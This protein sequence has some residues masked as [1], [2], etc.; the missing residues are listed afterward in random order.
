MGERAIGRACRR[1]AALKGEGTMKRRDFLLRASATVGMAM[2]LQ[3]LGAYAQG[4]QEVVFNGAGGTWQDN[5]R[6]AWLS[7]FSQ[8]T[9]ISVIDTFPFDVGKLSTM[10]RTGTVQWDVTDIPGEFLGL[11]EEQGLLEPIDYHI[12]DRHVLPPEDYG[13]HHVVYG[14]FSTNIVFNKQRFTGAERPANWSDYW[15]LRKFPGPRSFRRNPAVVLEAALLADGVA[16][17]KLYPLDVDRAFRKLDEIKTQVRWWTSAVQSVQLIA[18]GEVDLGV[19]FNSRAVVARD[20][21]VPLEVVWNQ[22]L[23][24]AVYLAVPKGARNKEG[25]M[26]LINYIVQ[27]DAQARMANLNR[28]APANLNA[29]AKIEPAILKDLPTAPENSHGAARIDELGFWAQNRAKL[30]KRFD[31]WLLI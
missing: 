11:A 15:D 5:A 13:Q 12:V 7:P 26:R 16:S 29:M 9:G 31:A 6:K 10:V 8:E 1:T 22:G 27:A 19:T 18:D 24:A 28:S 2:G 17:E 30:G 14:H 25:A 20:Q 21:G 4:G 23:V 3:N